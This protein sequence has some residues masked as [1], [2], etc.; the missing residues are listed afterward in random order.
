MKRFLEAGLFGGLLSAVLLTGP[1]PL[2]ADI[3]PP[4]PAPEALGRGPLHE[5]FA[6][7]IPDGLPKPGE[8]VP[9]TPPAPIQEQ[10]PEMKPEGDSEWIPGYWQWDD[11]RSEFLWQ[12]GTWRKPP[13]N[14]RWVPGSWNKTDNGYQYSPGF[15]APENSDGLQYLPP[16]PAPLEAGPST[17][18]PGDDYTYVP[19][20]WIYRDNRYAWR[21]GYWLQ[22]VPNWVWQPAHY[23]WS[24]AGYLFVPGGWDYP[25]DQRGLCF[26]PYYFP[27][28]AHRG[29]WTPS[30]CLN[31]N[32]LFGSLFIRPGYSSYYFGNYFSAGYRRAGYTPWVDYRIGRGGAYD[33]IYGHYR[34]LNAGRPAWD[35]NVRGLYSDRY[36]G[37]VAAPPRTL[38]QQNTLI[39]D[40]NQNRVRNATVSQV[41]MLQPISRSAPRGSSLVNVNRAERQQQL[42]SAAQFRSAAQQRVQ[43]QHNML[44]RREAPLRAN[45]T[46]RNVNLDLPKRERAVERSLQGGGTGQPRTDRSNYPRLDSNPTPRSAPGQGGTPRNLQQPRNVEQPRI[47]RTPRNLEQPRTPRVTPQPAPRQFEQPRT[48]RVNPQPAPRPNLNPPRVNNP[49]PAPR[50]RSVPTPQPTPRVNPPRVNVPRNNPAPRFRS[51]PPPSQPRFK[52]APAPRQQSAPR[53]AAPAP[54]RAAPAVHHSAP[55]GG[56]GGGHRR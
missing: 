46:P 7:P 55:R 9:K 50:I 41:T 30:Y 44:S 13:P 42:H 29:P 35:R 23:A 11:D 5:A 14:R 37:R 34:A 10:P 52:S 19:G 53:R 22:T 56:H 4:D 16:P 17:P 47:G 36:A 40:I 28:Y 8:V 38:V 48:P 6:Q 51:A 1:R 31:L 15:W 33:P 2:F 39:R 25:P 45:A 3:V 20:C 32:T 49:P 12:S 43:A 27:G 18:A 21:P 54:R 26:A 24:P